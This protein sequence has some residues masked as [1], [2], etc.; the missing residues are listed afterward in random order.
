[1]GSI[2]CHDSIAQKPPSILDIGDVVQLDAGHASD[3][4]GVFAHFFR[5]PSLKFPLAMPATNAPHLPHT[6]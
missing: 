4:H 6:L 1:M 2:Q 3:P 5:L